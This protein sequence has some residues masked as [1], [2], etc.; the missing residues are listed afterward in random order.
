MPANSRRST[1][2]REL[3]R[4]SSYLICDRADLVATWTN[5]GRGWLV[6]TDFG[7]VNAR[8][9][10]ERLPIEGDFKFVE[11]KLKMTDAGL[12]IQD[13]AV[14]QLAHR[15]ALKSLARDEDQILAVVTGHGALNRH[16]RTP[17]AA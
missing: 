5:N 4:Q 1:H 3:D 15:W 13:L 2:P 11:L 17:F 16:R 8:R 14:Y 6:A 12:C 7:L 10:P 9:N